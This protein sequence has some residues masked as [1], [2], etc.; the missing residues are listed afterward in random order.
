MKVIRVT[1]GGESFTTDDLTLDEA[2]QVERD[3]EETWLRLNPY[4]SAAHAKAILVAFITRTSGAAEAARVVG[5][6]TL[7]AALDCFSVADD[8]LPTIFEGGIPKEVGEPATTGSSGAPA[9]T[10]GLPA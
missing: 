3:T 10:V 6:M 4:R 1:V 9:S 5:A 7:A 2:I 8:D